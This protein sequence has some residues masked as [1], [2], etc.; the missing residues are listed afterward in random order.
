LDT[1]IGRAESFP[2]VLVAELLA[3]LITEEIA[4]EM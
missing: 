1:W 3:G 2:D 4:F